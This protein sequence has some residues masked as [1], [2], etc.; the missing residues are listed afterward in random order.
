M[1]VLYFQPN[2]CPAGRMKLLGA[3]EAARSAGVSLQLVESA[4]ADGRRVRR[5][6]EFWKPDACI[7]ESGDDVTYCPTEAFGPTPAVFIDRN[8]KSMPKSAMSVNI[9]SAAVGE[10]AAKELMALGLTNFACMP[11]KKDVFWANERTEAFVDALELNGRSCNVFKSP[12]RGDEAKALSRWLA[13]LPRPCGIF[14]ATDRLGA[15][16]LPSI[17]RIGASVP[18]DFAVVGVDNDEAICENTSP[19]LSSVAPDFRLAGSL[20]V[21][22]LLAPGRSTRMLFGISGLVRRASSFR[23]TAPL[24]GL[25][26][27]MDA[28]RT[29]A[30]DGLSAAEA[31]KTMGVSRRL[32]E[33]R[34]KA[35]AGKT[36]LQAIHEHRLEKAKY[37][38]C[39]TE[40]PLDA[41]PGLTGWKSSTAFRE[42]FR[43][44][45]GESMSSMRRRGRGGAA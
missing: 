33:M 25:S 10:A 34:F 16:L 23:P 26:A 28:I 13:A 7:V 40:T 15:V 22:A 11:V 9:D 21:K 29:R 27:A 32:A 3:Q 6:L 19:T 1:V 41:I 4:A 14:A 44:E 45:F 18:G 35:G 2:D 42:R 36:I 20:A 30:C 8:P 5:L 17:C 39:R 31:A 38:V 43:A 24:P 12:S 37:L